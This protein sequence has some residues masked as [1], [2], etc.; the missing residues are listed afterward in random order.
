MFTRIVERFGRGDWIRTSDPLR[1]RQ[2]RYQAALRPDILWSLDCRAFPALCF[3]RRHVPRRHATILRQETDVT[4]WFRLAC[5]LRIVRQAL[6]YAIGVGSL[7]III[8]HG[9]AILRSDLPIAR[10]LRMVLTLIVPYFVSTASS[11]SAIRERERTDST[12]PMI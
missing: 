10:L 12:S 2:V 11:V 6:G 3:P 7:L 9:D 5:S 8:N 1:P 4:E